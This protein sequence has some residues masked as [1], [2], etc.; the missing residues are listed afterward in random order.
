MDEN[1]T[2]TEGTTEETAAPA[3]EAATEASDTEEVSE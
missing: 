3:E 1:A 2:S